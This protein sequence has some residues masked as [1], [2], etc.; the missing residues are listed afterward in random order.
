[1]KKYLAILIVFV[2]STGA[3]AQSISF[4]ELTS[5]TNRTNNEVFD[6]LSDGRVFKQEYLEDVN[7]QMLDRFKNI[8]DSQK[9]ETIVFGKFSKTTDGSVLR[10]IN[11]SST[12]PQDLINL[13]SQVKRAGFDQL[14]RGV[15]ARS[16]IYIFD[17]NFY[18]VVVNLSLAKNINT[19]EIQQ[20]EYLGSE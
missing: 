2:C 6:Y 18:H 15:D 7:G 1:M 5:F 17:N 8:H 13:I 11:Y 16:N 12:E 9:L 14:L 10:T 19:L 3:Y 4:N 20:K